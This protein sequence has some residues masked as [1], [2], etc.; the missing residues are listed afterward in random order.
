MEDF[1]SKIQCMIDQEVSLKNKN[2]LKS[3]VFKHIEIQSVFSKIRFG[4]FRKFL[5]KR[6]LQFLHILF[7]QSARTF[8]FKRAVA[9]AVFVFL[10]VPMLSFLMIPPTVSMAAFYVQVSQVSGLVEVQ[11]GS[12]FFQIENEQKLLEGDRV[13]LGEGS[14]AEF[15]LPSIGIIRA[16]GGSDVKF[17]EVGD[18]YEN[19]KVQLDVQSGNVWVNTHEIHTSLMR[20]NVAVAEF[21]LPLEKNSL[22]NV[23]FDQQVRLSVL[24]NRVDVKTVAGPLE[25]LLAGQIL[26]SENGIPDMSDLTA[27]NNWI[28]ENL[29]AD[30]TLSPK[31]L[32]AEY[33]TS[34]DLELENLSDE[35]SLPEV[36]SLLDRVNKINKKRSKLSKKVAVLDAQVVNKDVTDV[37]Q[38]IYELVL[39]ANEIKPKKL[40]DFQEIDTLQKVLEN[41]L[42]QQRDLVEYLSLQ[43]GSLIEAKTNLGKALV[44]SDKK[45]KKLTQ[46]Q[47]AQQFLLD[48]RIQEEKSIDTEVIG[49][50]KE[51]LD[52]D[53]I[54]EAPLD[55]GGVIDELGEQEHDFESELETQ[56]LID[57][58]QENVDLLDDLAKDQDDIEVLEEIEEVKETLESSVDNLA[59]TYKFVKPESEINTVGTR[60]KISPERSVVK[61]NL[62]LDLSNDL[63]N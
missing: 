33:N 1:I 6:K 14:F 58:A 17:T 37:T 32:L 51:V 26:K 61:E 11:R 49:E 4:F 7:H 47:V 25:T 2:A 41:E 22:V 23:D 20:L 21:N 24:K 8:V 29:S 43:D 3:R 34:L 48:L 35:A 30:K 52:E 27:S 55:E 53:L 31:V 63:Q 15:Y 62:D 59:D 18:F 38:E 28:A 19:P 36:E 5:L 45:G 44:A 50:L 54:Q 10:T 39:D 46:M 9:M 57:V 40:E 13:V 42:N 16:K 12:E 56:Q 60:T